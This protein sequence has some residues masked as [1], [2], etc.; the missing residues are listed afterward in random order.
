MM[1]EDGI[2]KLFFGR[3]LFGRM[4]LLDI[5]ILDFVWWEV[6]FYYGKLLNFG[7]ICYKI[8]IIDINMVN[9]I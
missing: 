3:N 1:E 8:S 9:N 7:L 2:F 5:F 6:N 4:F